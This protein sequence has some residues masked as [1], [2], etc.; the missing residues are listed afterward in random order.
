MSR[1]RLEKAFNFL[2]MRLAKMSLQLFYDMITKHFGIGW[3]VYIS[4]IHLGG[5]HFLKGKRV[6]MDIFHFF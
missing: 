3:K 4:E 1:G 2:V 5:I 6:F